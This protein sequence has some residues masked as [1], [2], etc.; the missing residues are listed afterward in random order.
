M[1]NIVALFRLD[2]KNNNV[3]KAWR[4]YCVSDTVESRNKSC[5]KQRGTSFV[6]VWVCVL[7]QKTQEVGDKRDQAREEAMPIMKIMRFTD[8]P[9][10]K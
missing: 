5:A 2:K 7:K 9:T 3:P 1:E 6:F 8:T 4:Q 10:L